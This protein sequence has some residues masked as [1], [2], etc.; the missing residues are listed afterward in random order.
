MN[1]TRQRHC[2]KRIDR[3]AHAELR[4]Q[5]YDRVSLLTPPV[6][7][8]NYLI[9][10]D[11][12]ITFIDNLFPARSI[13]SVANGFSFCKALD[14]INLHSLSDILFAI[15]IVVEDSLSIDNFDAAYV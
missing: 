3:T 6:S 15:N 9:L 5:P 13:L 2:R 4:H 1:T 8:E 12:L 7:R 14:H 11:A 10:V